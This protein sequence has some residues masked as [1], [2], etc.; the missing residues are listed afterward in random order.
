[1]AA[2]SATTTRPPGG[3]DRD[4]H[5]VQFYREDAFLLDVVAGWFGDALEA[6]NP[7]VAIATRAHLPG[8]TARLEA[9]GI[10]VDRESRRG[11]ITL[12]ECRD[13]MS[14]FM[15]DLL[16]DWD[17]FSRAIAPVLEKASKAAAGR[18]VTAFGEMVDVLCRDGN[19]R[20]ASR[21]EQLWDE[22][23]YS[24]DFRLLCGYS[25]SNFQGDHATRS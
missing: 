16:P 2:S 11:V 4:R 13:V 5:V 19:G 21:L 6:G 23:G 22:L 17:G 15:R 9:R 1:M 18:P 10:D 12:L 14:Q 3:A 8:I 24:H 20:A 7:I 25:M